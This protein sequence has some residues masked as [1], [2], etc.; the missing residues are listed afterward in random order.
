MILVATCQSF[1]R[2]QSF[3]LAGIHL[4][5][6]YLFL[7]LYLLTWKPMGR[8]LSVWDSDFS[9][10]KKEKKIKVLQSG[11]RGIGL[12]RPIQ[13]TN[14]GGG[15]GGREWDKE[16]ERYLEEEEEEEDEWYVDGNSRQ[17]HVRSAA[18]ILPHA[19][20]TRTL[21]PPPPPQ[22]SFDPFP[23]LPICHVYILLHFFLFLQSPLAIL[24]FHSHSSKIPSSAM[25]SLSLPSFTTQ[26]NTLTV[27]AYSSVVVVVVLIRMCL[28]C[29]VF[30]FSW[31]YD[32]W[33]G[34]ILFTTLIVTRWWRWLEFVWHRLP[35][36]S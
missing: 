20:L 6:I 30:L 2:K 15:G 4:S 32:R 1:G 27:S 11:I 25:H 7:I 3:W 14:F 21:P 18:T 8:A 26:N 36:A 9:W 31:F 22:S 5:S 17:T 12:G 35:N 23:L 19:T 29:L 10:K 16:K 13:A 33:L 24:Q 28:R 34:L